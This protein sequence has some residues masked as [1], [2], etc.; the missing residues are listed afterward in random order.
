V[1]RPS[2]APESAP[3]DGAHTTADALVCHRARHG[4]ARDDAFMTDT[5]LSPSSADVRAVELR[6][7]N[8]WWLWLVTG[9]IWLIAA[10]VILQFDQAS[11]TTVGIL[12]GCMFVLSGVQQFVVASLTDRLRWLWIVFGALFVIA[13]IICFINPEA[14][15][16]GLA[17]ILGFLFL[18][19]GVW[20]AVEALV[21]KAEDSLWW[22]RLIS[23]ILMLVV[24]FWTSGQFFITKAYTLLVFAGVWA[25]LQGVTD[26]IRAFQVRSLRS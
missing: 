10:L 11:I 17:D 8:F 19:V 22:L 21:S 1:E 25:L 15:F 24:A 14:T 4:V 26:I 2:V 12:V 20:W 3:V 9:V 6:L 13:G 23:A 16:A 18:L 5:A 7:P